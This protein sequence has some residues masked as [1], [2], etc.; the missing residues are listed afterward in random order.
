[1][2]LP[3]CRICAGAGQEAVALDL[4]LQPISNRFKTGAGENE[5]RHPLRVAQCPHCGLVQTVECFP[6]EALR[7]REAW[8]RYR[9]RD[10]HLPA[11]VAQ[12]GP[13]F[14]G[15]PT[16]KTILGVTSFDTVLGDL[17][18]KSLALPYAQLD[19]RSDLGIEEETFGMETFQ[20]VLTPQRAQE[21]I[22]RRGRCGVFITRYLL[23][24]AESPLAM[25]EAI[26]TLLVDNGYVLVEIPE[27]APALARHDYAIV[28]EEHASFFTEAT[29]ISALAAGGFTTR[30]AFWASSKFEPPLL[31]LAQK[32]ASRPPTAVGAPAERERFHAF[33]EA[34]PKQRAAWLR[35]CKAGRARRQPLALFG[36]GHFAVAFA[37]YFGLAEFFDFVIDDD[38]N[39]TGRVLPG[40]TLS[41]VPSSTLARHGNA[42]VLLCV[43]PDVEE[44]L[45]AKLKSASLPLK[46]C[47]SIFAASARFG[48]HE[49]PAAT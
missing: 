23:E 41:I 3:R 46:D 47:Y 33:V 27:A 24:H 8:I 14:S 4:G 28:W 18:G 44:R 25:L 34:F 10:D 31:M 26:N 21:I 38:P 2:I 49:P 20:R 5:V 36:A 15:L 1:M 9:E 29:L 6:S 16:D 32:T 37:S 35:F 42:L 40:T 19:A 45:V 17:L 13:I 43:N 30:R 48:L 7:P 39:K 11:C 22:A 12:F